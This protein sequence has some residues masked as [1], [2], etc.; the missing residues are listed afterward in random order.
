MARDGRFAMKKITNK[1]YEEY[2][3]YKMDVVKGRVLT[4]DGIRL[5][6]EANN[7]DPMRIG[8][9]VLD[10]YNKAIAEK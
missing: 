10:G 8:K 4:L 3:A 5:I 2:Q 7:N 9:M 1:E 6:V